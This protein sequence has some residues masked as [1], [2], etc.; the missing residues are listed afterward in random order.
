LDVLI[1]TP[2]SHLIEQCGGNRKTLSRVIMGGPMMGFALHDDEVP[3]VKTTNCILVNSVI[4]D[5]PLPS[6][7][8]AALPCIRCG[9]CAQA[10][11]AG[12][13][14]QQLYWYAR[15]RDFDKVQDYN[16]F[17]CIE[18]GC[19]DYVCPSQ[20]PLVQ[21]YR[22]AK[23]AIWQKEKEKTVSDISRQRHEFH[24]FRQER[25]KQERELR[26]KQKR[27]AVESSS[28]QDDKKAAIQAAMERV[29]KKR[30]HSDVTPKNVDNL[31]EQQKTL[32][33]EVDA[34]RKKKLEDIK[35]ENIT[36]NTSGRDPE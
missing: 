7:A 5:V 2:V 10:C 17:D 34:R 15:A 11:P 16:L 14:P 32:I 25:E 26:H 8:S 24:N 31:T 27:Q 19:C 1:G 20:I 23:T 4:S 6:R 28:T 29:R 21:Y 22:Y 35:S 30:E 33:E 9:A 36:I 18:C 3:V 12:L 13:L